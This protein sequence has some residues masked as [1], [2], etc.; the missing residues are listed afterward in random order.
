[1]HIFLP[2]NT[3]FQVFSNSKLIL[4]VI[5]FSFLCLLFRLK[6]QT[7]NFSRFGYSVETCKIT[8]HE[9]I[10]DVEAEEAYSPENAFQENRNDIVG[11]TEDVKSS[12]SLGNISKNS[13]GQSPWTIFSTT[14]TTTTP[15]FA[16]FG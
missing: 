12:E 15:Y 5:A 9:P 7:V 1:M 14:P 11:T 13:S 2:T 3:M 10:E 16:T 6:L 4:F 8:G